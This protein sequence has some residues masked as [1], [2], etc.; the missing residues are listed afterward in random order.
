MFIVFIGALY[1]FLVVSRKASNDVK[2]PYEAT[3]IVECSLAFY[4]NAKVVVS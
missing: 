2:D 1:F 4:F 3:N